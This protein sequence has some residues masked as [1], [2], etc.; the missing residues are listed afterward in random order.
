MK[1]TQDVWD[2][3]TRVMV[4]SLDHDMS[5]S[6]LRLTVTLNGTREPS[7]AG[8]PAVA[9]TFSTPSRAAIPPYTRS[10]SA[11]SSP[12]GGSS[13]EAIARQSDRSQP[14]R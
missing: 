6:P 10:M 1:C 14:D 9:T 7:A 8:V 3:S 5:P 13:W 12:D 11:A 2:C 4:S